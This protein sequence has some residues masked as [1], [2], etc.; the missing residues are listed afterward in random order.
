MMNFVYLMNKTFKRTFTYLL[1]GVL[2]TYA[3]ISQAAVQQDSKGGKQENK[4]E[5]T[6]RKDDSKKQVKEVP[7]SRKQDRPE[8][9]RQQKK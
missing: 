5:Q 9:V 7:K 3:F 8:P 4:S 2:T 6:Q 1:I